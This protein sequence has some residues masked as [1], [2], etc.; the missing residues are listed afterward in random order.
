M[1]VLLALFSLFTSQGLS[2]PIAPSRYLT[3]S[4]VLAV[5]FNVSLSST[6]VLLPHQLLDTIPA[7][8]VKDAVCSLSWLV[9]FLSHDSSAI[10]NAVPH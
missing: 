5:N 7:S 1:F 10:L 8:A 9:D 2:T 4:S 6:D 3:E